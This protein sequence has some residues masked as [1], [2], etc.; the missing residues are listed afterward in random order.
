MTAFNSNT[1]L[2]IKRRMMAYLR[3]E[4]FNFYESA[5]L[6]KLDQLERDALAIEWA[7]H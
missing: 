4:G 1:D 6:L 3:D 2:F 7:E 5:T